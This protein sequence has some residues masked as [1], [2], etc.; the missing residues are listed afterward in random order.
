FKLAIPN[1]FA[2]MF[3]IA[4]GLFFFGKSKT[5][6]TLDHNESKK[7]FLQGIG[8]AIANPQ[9]IMYWTLVSTIVCQSINIFGSYS[10]FYFGIGAYLGTFIALTIYKKLGTNNMF[11][12]IDNRLIYNS[13]GLFFIIA[14]FIK[15][16]SI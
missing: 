5:L 2:A 1:I 3:L 15:L 16:L 10:T 13:L 7:Y 6:D 9:V 14:G 4:L 8:F 11:N 12:Q